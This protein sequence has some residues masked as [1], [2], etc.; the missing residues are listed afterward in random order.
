MI[1]NEHQPIEWIVD[2]EAWTEWRRLGQGDTVVAS[3][4]PTIQIGESAWAQTASVS[5]TWMNRR[6]ENPSG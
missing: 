6:A 4:I 3:L 2:A 1:G 5:I